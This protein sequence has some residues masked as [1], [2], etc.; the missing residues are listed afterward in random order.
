MYYYQPVKAHIRPK[1]ID[2]VRWVRLLA[3]RRW[4]FEDAFRW[5]EGDGLEQLLGNISANV[6]RCFE[7]SGYHILVT[8]GGIEHAPYDVFPDVPAAIAFLFDFFDNVLGEEQFDSLL[9][10]PS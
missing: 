6:Y 10:D 3:Y 2:P 4:K 1:S 8:G 5:A 9:S 7:C